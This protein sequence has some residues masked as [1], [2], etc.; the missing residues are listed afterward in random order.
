MNK[1]NTHMSVQNNLQKYV[2][3]T[4]SFINDDDGYFK[5]KG[6]FKHFYMYV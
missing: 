1:F 6:F 4:F 2:Y 5:N 3:F